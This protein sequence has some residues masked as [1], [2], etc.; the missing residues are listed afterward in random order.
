MILFF[1]DW[2]ENFRVTVI[3]RAELNLMNPQLGLTSIAYLL[4]VWMR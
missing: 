2:D 1:I 3:V 4:L